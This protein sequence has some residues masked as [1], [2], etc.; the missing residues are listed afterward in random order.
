[1]PSYKRQSSGRVRK[2]LEKS[3]N[4]V[5]RTLG[6]CRTLYVC[7]CVDYICIYL[8]LSPGYMSHDCHVVSPW[9]DRNKIT[10]ILMFELTVASRQRMT[11]KKECGSQWTP[12][13]V[14]TW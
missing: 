7:V 10:T 13:G 5:K 14:C 6:L 11:V 3:K 2:I 12:T 9:D 8:R 1:M 4:I